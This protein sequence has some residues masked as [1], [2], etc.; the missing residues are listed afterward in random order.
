[1]ADIRELGKKVKAK[2]PGAYDD[3]DDAALG[4]SVKTKYPGQYD[5]FTDEG[6]IAAID[7]PKE[8]GWM[9]TAVS[10]G[11]GAIDAAKSVGHM[12][13]RVAK[14]PQDFTD[15]AAM[16]ATASP[17]APLVVDAIKGQWE[18]GKKAIE[19]FQQ[20]ENLQGAGYTAAAALPVLGPMAAGFGEKAA[21]TNP[22]GTPMEGA[23][24]R[25]IGEGATALLL[26]AVAKRVGPAMGASSDMLKESAL[27][28][29]SSV[30]GAGTKGNKIRSARV[31]PEL[32][33]RG[34]MSPSL[35][36]IAEKATTE[37]NIA[38]EAISSAFE[39]LPEGSRIPLE[40]LRQRLAN[41]AQDEFML[42]DA[43]GVLKPMSAE[44]AR[45][46]DN[47][48]DIYK[49]ISDFAEID[50]A[51]GQ[52]FIPAGT[53]RR[54]RQYYDQVTKDAGGFEGKSLSD[55]SIAGA[56][57]M[58]ADAIRE[59][60]ASEYPDIAKINKEYS[61]WKDVQKLS[62]DRLTTRQGQQ[63]G[64]GQK[65]AR[66]AGTAAGFTEGGFLGA[67]GGRAV[68][69]TLESL[70][71]SPAWKTISAVSKDRL[72]NALAKGRRGEAEHLIRTM[73]AT[74]VS[75]QAREAG[76]RKTEEKKD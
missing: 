45:S 53:A 44:A 15:A 25:A 70:V 59:G 56:H 9:D 16:L 38:G 42:A 49:N 76:K 29:Y 71:S 75:S 23:I 24:P 72:A 11:E 30:L 57:K 69:G 36:G 67:L 43:N 54:L 28:E 55:K 4:R 39:G 52:A 74:M 5:D 32:V 35:K 47:I 65:M 34:V 22:D 18:T 8:R 61:F 73:R 21:A 10:L 40:P 3:M 1:M 17:L 50:K 62:E 2:Y 33:D 51:S 27:Q 31:V 12:V 64:I 66:I 48:K 6:P 68:V 63:K 37:A 58:G 26:P 7:K 14:G 13:E 19:S 60:L 46:V 20:G 41:L